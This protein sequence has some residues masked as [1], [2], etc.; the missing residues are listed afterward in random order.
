MSRPLKSRASSVP[1]RGSRGSRKGGYGLRSHG[2][3]RCL[4][5]NLSPNPLVRLPADTYRKMAFDV[6]AGA[7]GNRAVKLPDSK[8]G[9]WENQE[10]TFAKT[11]SEPPRLHR[12]PGR[13]AS[14]RRIGKDVAGGVSRRRQGRN[15]KT[16][17]GSTHRVL[18]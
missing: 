7:L 4:V 8:N 6:G 15:D 18:C 12:N 17:W 13:R 5:I 1:G 16:P 14:K 3:I 11:A 2:R 10:R 9:E